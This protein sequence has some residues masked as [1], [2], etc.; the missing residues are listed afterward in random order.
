MKKTKRVLIGIIVAI[1]LAVVGVCIWQ[2]ENVN[3]FLL[4]TKYSEEELA[5]V[6]QEKRD[7]ATQVLEKYEGITA[8]NLTVEQEDALIDGKIS[9]EEIIAELNATKNESESNE[10]KSPTN[11]E[12]SIASKESEVI[13]RYLY[14]IYEIK[15]EFLGKLSVIKDD[16]VKAYIALPKDKR[17]RDAKLGIVADRILECYEL[18]NSCDI[19]IEKVL[20]SLKTELVGI[21][22]DT[23]IV[24]EIREAYKNEKSTKKA[25]YL[26]KLS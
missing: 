19:E 4:Y 24:S 26:S 6:L 11:S 8:V 5:S 10:K 15:A 21:G 17:T 22:A 18:E 13:N 12:N 23:S 7:Q 2:W 9:A 1:L 3:A 16:A 14:K 25:Y 20:T